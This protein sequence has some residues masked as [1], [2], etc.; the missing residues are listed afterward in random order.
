M[1]LNAIPLVLESPLAL[2]NRLHYGLSQEGTY[3]PSIFIRRVYRLR[4]WQYTSHCCTYIGACRVKMMHAFYMFKDEGPILNG[5]I[6][7]LNRC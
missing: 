3:N 4:H 2:A 5:L 7:N 1:A 6:P